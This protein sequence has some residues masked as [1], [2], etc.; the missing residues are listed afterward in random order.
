YGRGGG[1]V[2]RG[3]AEGAGL[4]VMPGVPV[5]VAVAVTTGVAV[6]V[7]VG[8]RVAVA[9][10]VAVTIAVAVG[11]AV[12]VRVAVAVAVGVGE[13]PQ[14]LTGQLK[15][16][17]SAAGVVGSYPAANQ[18]R[19]VPSVSVGKLRRAFTNGVPIDQLLVPGS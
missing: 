17:M 16:S 19:L 9:V 2:G 14:G 12:G 5:G 18:M 10:A 11:V 3:R 8:V 15:I 13:A 4:G 7:A 6:G 1:V